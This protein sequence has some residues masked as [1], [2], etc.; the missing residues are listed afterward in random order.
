MAFYNDLITQKSWQTLQ[1]LRN[2]IDFILIGGWAVYFYTKALKSK[3][4][5]III[6]YETLPKL[7]D[8]FTVT[9]NIRLTKYEARNEEVQIDIYLPFYS[10][11][12]IPVNAVADETTVIDTFSL[13]TPEILLIMKQY[14]LGERKL[15]VK[16]EKDRL[17]IL[18]LLSK[19]TFDFHKYQKYLRKFKQENLFI[20]LEKLIRS[21]T[22][23][24]ELSIN[25]HAW[26]RIKKKLIQQ[27]SS[28]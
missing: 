19:V 9:K 28:S 14:T 21:T 22:K 1:S 17:D 23:V 4:I 18:S 25:E 6:N 15:S 20:E 12:G 13:P 26:S 7:K 2:Q 5:D 8:L 27:M 3:D 24:P 10:H 11:L 16:G